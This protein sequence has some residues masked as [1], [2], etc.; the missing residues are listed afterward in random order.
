MNMIPLYHLTKH[1]G[2]ETKRLIDVPKVKKLCESFGIPYQYA[3]ALQAETVNITLFTIARVYVCHSV[4][5][6]Q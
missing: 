6:P 3:Y 1:R 5:L 2:G 4:R